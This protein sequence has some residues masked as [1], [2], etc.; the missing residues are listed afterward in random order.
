M[1][2][3]GVPIDYTMHF[4]VENATAA[5]KDGTAMALKEMS[6][7]RIDVSRTMMVRGTAIWGGYMDKVPR[8]SESVL[9]SNPL[10]N[11]FHNEAGFLP[12]QTGRRY[13]EGPMELAGR[14]AEA[15]ALVRTSRHLTPHERARLKM[16]FLTRDQARVVI[17][18]LWNHIVRR[19]DHSMEG[20]QPIG[21][22]RS[23]KFQQW[24]PDH[25]LAA[26]GI[27]PSQ[28]FNGARLPGSES[29]L[30]RWNGSWRKSA[31]R[32]RFPNCILAPSCAF[33]TITPQG[34]I[35][36]SEIV[37]KFKNEQ[38]VYRI[39]NVQNAKKAL[40][41]EMQVL[42]YF[43][44][45]DMSMIH[46]T[47]GERAYLGSIPRTRGARRLD[48]KAV[49]EQIKASRSALHNL[50]ATVSKRMPHVAE[51]HLEQIENNKAVIEE[52][53]RNQESIDLA[54]TN[55]EQ[56]DSPRCR[57]PIAAREAQPAIG[58]P[59]G[60]CAPGGNRRHH[61][62]ARRAGLHTKTFGKRIGGN[63]LERW[64]D[65]NKFW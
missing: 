58:D 42:C 34:K 2:T 31:V 57:A 5:L 1:T 54:S 20:F 18:D 62:A 55:G 7:D 37:F 16:P 59:Q 4:V 29:P 21:E 23:E 27:D 32:P 63:A 50:Q 19:T 43:D 6:C 53:V 12:G 36:N 46:L 60:R 15:K 40:K 13:D 14:E 38:S 3:Y 39:A 8:Q 26:L 33:T 30:E 48:V 45:E 25:E 24:K 9:R 28:R 10:F 35:I 17:N 22:W 65:T 44:R 61:A 47:D 11:L 51:E 41:N 64:E 56:L 52:A 49:E